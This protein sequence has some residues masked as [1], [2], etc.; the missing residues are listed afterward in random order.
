MDKVVV[1]RE[2]PLT[3]ALHTKIR[4]QGASRHQFVTC[5]DRLTQM[6]LEEALGH[7]PATEVEVMT[8][9]GPYK[10]V[11]LPEESQ[12]CAISILRAAD[13]ML[14]V[15]RS[16][17]PSI[18]VGKV[19]IQRDEETALPALMYAKLPPDIATRPA[20]LVL[21]P[22]LATG[23]SAIMCV[24]VLVEKGVDPKKIIFVNVVCVKEG[25]E[26]LAAAYPDV[27]V[28]T[29]AI[30]PILNEKKYIVPG[31]GDFG[32]RYFGTDGN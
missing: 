25:I 11:A 27:K 24:K 28:V 19:L 14:G 13:C 4:D 12:L 1:L 5:S 2:T 30:D 23:G 6:L 18:A 21:D 26:A 29:G 3:R 32:D 20:V 31:L 9:C 22:M 16:T 8:P 10:G 7:L 17:M 15:V